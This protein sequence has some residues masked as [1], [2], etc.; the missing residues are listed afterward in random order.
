[1]HPREQIDTY[2]ALDKKWKPTKRGV[3]ATAYQQALI[4]L[5]REEMFRKKQYFEIEE[6]RYQTAKVPRVE[7]ILAPRYA[8]GVVVHRTHFPELETSLLDWPNGYL[9]PPDSVA[10]AIGLL[11]PFAATAAGE[12]FDLGEDEYPSLEDEGLNMFFG[13]P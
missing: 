7:G 6:I 5:L 8:A 1:M 10:M 9:D 2:F 13:A 4:H 11:D 12:D 3:E